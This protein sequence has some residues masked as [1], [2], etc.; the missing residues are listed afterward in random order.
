[1]YLI[2]SDHLKQ[3]LENHYYPKKPESELA[4]LRARVEALEHSLENGRECDRKGV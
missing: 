3:L 1:M 2:L 4:N